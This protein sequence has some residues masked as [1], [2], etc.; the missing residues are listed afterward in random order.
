[1]SL[2]PCV[3]LSV[4]PERKISDAAKLTEF[5]NS[6]HNS[7]CPS[8]IQPLLTEWLPLPIGKLLLPTRQR[9]LIGRVSGLVSFNNA[10]S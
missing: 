10:D 7:P 1:M 5:V 4:R 2:G 8:K 9:L 3:C 6:E